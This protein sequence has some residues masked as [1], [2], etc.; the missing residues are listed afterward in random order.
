VNFNT[1]AED[2]EAVARI[3]SRLGR[4]VDTELRPAELKPRG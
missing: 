1:R 4:E 2:M 3:S